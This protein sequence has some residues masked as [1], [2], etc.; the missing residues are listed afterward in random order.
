MG[1]TRNLLLA[2]IAFL[3]LGSPDALAAPPPPENPVTDQA[4]P[5]WFKGN[6]HTHSL[7]SDG[8]DY[9]EMIVDWY[10]RHGY[11][12][13]ALSDHNVLSQGRALDERGPGRQAGQAR[14]LRPLPPAVR[15][16]LGRDSHRQTATSRSG[17]SH[18]AS[19]ATSSS[20]RA[21]SC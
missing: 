9:P 6:L 3:V 12:F 18:W 15:G 17:S 16:R 13:L 11:Q 2:L 1:S 7:W 20:G 10:T 21:S 4:E 14:R 5:R 8:N 19:S